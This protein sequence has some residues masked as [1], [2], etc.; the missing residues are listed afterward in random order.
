ALVGLLVGCSSSPSHRGSAGRPDRSAAVTAIRKAGTQFE[1]SVQVHPLIDPAV[2]GLLHQARE[3]E[4]QGQPAQ[5]LANVR[6]ALTITP[7]APELLQYEAELLIETGDWKQ[8]ESRA[9]QSYQLGPKVGGLCARSLE[10]LVWTRFALRDD[11]GVKQ[12]QQ[13]LAGCRVPD[14]HRY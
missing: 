3:L 13:Q 9:Q 1:S 7:K 11:A 10:T 6:K 4:A 12:A 5:A 8:A 14:R 2:E